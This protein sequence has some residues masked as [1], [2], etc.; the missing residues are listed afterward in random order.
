M[1]GK[2]KKPREALALLVD[3]LV[4]DVLTASDQEII[5]EFVEAQG[6][7]VKNAE[8]M[9][10]LFEKSVLTANKSR[11]HA[12]K[13]GLAADQA[14][15]TTPKVVSMTH[16][17]DRLKRAIASCPPEVKLTLAARKES[18]L[19][20]ADVLGM[21]QDLKELGIIIPDDESGS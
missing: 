14:Q 21:L 18:E 16:V 9:R 17:R 20:D 13:A 5:A 11:L 8:T 15:P 1:T 7:P 19:S 4:E 12:A 10:A 2:N 3:A 6:D